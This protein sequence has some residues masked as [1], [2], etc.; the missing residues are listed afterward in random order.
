MDQYYAPCSICMGQTSHKVLH[1]NRVLNDQREETVVKTF[2][3][4]QCAGCND[5]CLE[6][7]R[8]E[9]FGQWSRK[10]YPSPVSRKEPDWVSFMSAEM[11]DDE[12]IRLASLLREIYQAVDA[13]Q[14]RLAAM[15]IRALLEQVMILK[16]GDLKTFDDKL[17]AFQKDG[18]ISSLQRDSMRATLDVGDAAMHR[19]FKPTESDL[20]IALDIVEG[21]F[22][23]IFGHSDAAKQLANR[24]PA[25][26]PRPTKKPR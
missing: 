23:P 6:V 2:T 9:Q 1:K 21:V 18:N 10:Y 25:R 11:S 19:A 15:G 20:K 24:V 12:E 22:A 13:G 5:V 16:I 7:R 3:M 26:V 8:D 14:H 4:L 17:D